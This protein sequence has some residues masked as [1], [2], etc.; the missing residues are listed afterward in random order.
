[1]FLC[2]RLL[3]LGHTRPLSHSSAVT[4]VRCHTRPLSHSSSVTLVLC[5]TRPLSHSSAVTPVL[6]HT[7]L[8]KINKTIVTRLHKTGAVQACNNT[9]GS[10]VCTCPRGTAGAGYAQ[11]SDCPDINECTQTV[12]DG[13]QAVYTHNCE[14]RVCHACFGVVGCVYTHNCEPRVCYICV[15]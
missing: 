6:C 12:S 14:P 4:L 1:M 3:P 11:A 10:Y 8:M 13:F 15:V 7:H 2:K 9:Q 5:H